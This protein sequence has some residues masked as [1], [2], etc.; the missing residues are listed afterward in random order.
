ML[1]G[2]ITIFAFWSA[3]GPDAGLYRVFYETLPI[4]TFLRAPGRM[5][6]MV[7]LAGVVFAS[8]AIAHVIERTSKPHVSAAALSLLAV[9]EL[10][11]MPLTQFR[12]VTPP[13]PAY[14]VLATLPP[15]AVA[16]FPWWYERLDFPRHAEY[17]L[18][19]TT[20]W[21]PL[22]NGYSDHIPADFRKRVLPMSSFPTRESFGLL[23]QAEARYAVFHLNG[24][25]ERSKV[26]LF[27]RLKTYSEYLRP[28]YQDESVWLFEIVGWPN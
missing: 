13:S 27:E 17:M 24:Y 11:T 16:E 7:T 10:W 28:L 15:G 23:A 18:N 12:D 22:V 8:I 26:R 20:H 5:G 21:K 19:S 4:F 25:N 2:L 9:A 1:Y 14:Q 6:L 3:F